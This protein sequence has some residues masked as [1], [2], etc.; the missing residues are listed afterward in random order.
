MPHKVAIDFGTTNSVVAVWDEVGACARLL[1]LSELSAPPG[2]SHLP[3]VPSLLYVVDGRNGQAI[4]GQP[5]CDQG[6]DRRRDNRL[7]RN[8]KRG[9]LAATAVEPRQI[10]G[11]SWSDQVAG[12]AFL[13]LLLQAL[14]YQTQQVAELALAVPAAAFESYL[15]WL[16][17][18]VRDLEAQKIRVVDEAT[19]A[20]LGYAVTEPGALVFVFDFGGG[21]LDLSLVQLPQ[22]RAQSGGF[23]SRLLASRSAREHAARVV[24]KAGH[25]IGGSDIDQ[26]LLD[27]LLQQAGL[28]PGCLG[29][30]YPTLLAA[31]ERAKIALSTTEV[32]TVTFPDEAGGHL[33]TVTRGDLEG[34]LAQ[35]GFYQVLRRLID[36]VLQAAHC[37]G[38]FREDVQAVLMVGG[39]SLMPSV[40]ALLGDYFDQSS[41]RADKPFTAVA[42]GALHLAAG[43]GLDDYLGHGYGLRYL[44]PAG[45]GHR[46]EEIIPAGSRFPTPE[47]VAVILGAAY[48]GQTAVEFVIGEIAAG[49]A[50]RVDVRYEN[51]QA[52]FVARLDA[53]AAATGAAVVPINEREAGSHPLPLS[54]PAK[55]GPDR[56]KAHFT[57]DAGR[58]LRLSV[59]DLH[60]GRTLWHDVLLAGLEPE[61]RAAGWADAGSAAPAPL[62]SALT[63]REPALAATAATS[64]RRLSLRGLATMLNAL[65]PEAVSLPALAAALR[66]DDFYVRY[67]AAEM[68]GRRGDRDARRIMQ[69]VLDSGP[70]RLRASVARHLHR[71][72]W[73]SAEPL[74]RQTMQDPDLRVHESAVYALCN[75]RDEAA[76]ALLLELLPRESDDVRLAVAYGLAGNRDAD[77]VPVLAVALQAAEADVRAK[78]LE[79]LGSTGRP[80]ALPVVRAAVWHDPDPEVKYAAVLS[81]MELAEEAS[82]AEIAAAIGAHT[83][84]ARRQIL[85]AFFHAGNYLHLDV[86]RSVAAGEILAALSSAL[87][88]KLP[89]VRL[90]AAWPLILM[91]HEQATAVL[92]EAYGR[93]ENAAVRESILEIAASF[94]PELSRRLSSSPAS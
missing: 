7:F 60:S 87:A 52:L 40:Q 12:Q 83:G 85:R 51:G 11:T 64:E 77:A 25:V 56:L 92:L 27:H 23:L 46:Y 80:E 38:I 61:H 72:S 5:V 62:E 35:H 53:G 21:T 18:A 1:E 29:T 65:P 34:L 79:T 70:A 42:T 50:A 15:V 55:R 17:G 36:R 44:D 74:L 19:A 10:D 93:E 37:R 94:N 4:A 48:E 69:E 47:P 58:Q 88:D 16:T 49:E 24:A 73:F 45:G 41:L 81:L 82:L 30:A 22:S 57:V 89:E 14:P 26:W 33:I 71:F 75:L 32:T 67:S 3:L 6:L 90:A 63:G 84:E 8:F 43:L 31:C 20:A 2:K 68:L 13:R 78:V 59:V 28:E 91:E 39:T 86:G 76:Y 66:S 54:P 9:L